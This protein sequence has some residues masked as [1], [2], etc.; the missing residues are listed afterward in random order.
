MPV[1]LDVALG[2]CGSPSVVR[3]PGQTE[4]QTGVGSCGCYGDCECS[5]SSETHFVLGEDVVVVVVM[6]VVV[7][8][9]GSDGRCNRVQRVLLLDLSRNEC[10]NDKRES[11]SCTLAVT[12]RETKKGG[13]STRDSRQRL[14]LV[15]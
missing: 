3:S 1:P 15:R 8:V 6:V 9:L 7:V 4:T 13:G 5:D 10:Q 2:D 14:S 11:C 12:T